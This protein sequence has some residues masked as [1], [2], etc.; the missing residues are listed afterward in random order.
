L[1]GTALEYLESVL[2]EP[3]RVRLWPFIETE[4]Q[5]PGPRR[6]AEQALQELLASR[7]SIV[8]ALAAV[9]GRASG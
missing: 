7:E 9:R 4:Q 6:S 5:Q 3:V 8:L 2:P 1:R